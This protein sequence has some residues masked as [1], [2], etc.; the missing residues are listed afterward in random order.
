MTKHFEAARRQRSRGVTLIELAI[1]IALVGILGALIV[2]FIYPVRAYLDT[3]RRAA[4]ADT[5]DTALRRIGRDLRLALPNSVRVTNSGGVVYLEFLEVR[6]AGRYRYE[7]GPGTDCGGTA[8]QD[9]LAF[10]AADSC[11]TTIGGVDNRADIVGTDYVVVYNLPFGTDKASA[12]QTTCGVTCNKA[13]I[14]TFPPAAG[15]GGDVI[16][17]SSNTFTYES[18]GRRFFIIRGPV[19][20]ACDKSAGTLRRYASYS[21]QATPQPAPPGGAS[22]LL[23]SGVSDCSIDYDVAG[24]AN[25]GAGLVSMWLQLRMQNSGGTNE[26]VNLYHAVHVS[27]VP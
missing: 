1:T 24:K 27:N 18:P 19:T 2:Y 13:Q 16:R 9:A 20:Y 7:A 17:F 6:T 26:D 8:A 21:I 23:A 12:Y 22:A 11:F 15:T 4:L 25:Q 10:G 14:T 3:S 5:A